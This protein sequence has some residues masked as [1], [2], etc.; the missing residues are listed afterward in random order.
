MASWGFVDY[1]MS[2]ILICNMVWC[3]I[4]GLY[5]DSSISIQHYHKPNEQSPEKWEHREQTPANNP[6]THHTTPKTLFKIYFK[7]PSEHP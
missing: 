5:T 2:M 6:T 1:C 3:L 4:V 7:C